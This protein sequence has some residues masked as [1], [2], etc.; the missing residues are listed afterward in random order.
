M[1]KL[2]M[3]PQLFLVK[4]TVHSTS[5]ALDIYQSDKST[6]SSAS[7]ACFTFST[8]SDTAVGASS[9]TFCNFSPAKVKEAVSVLIFLDK[10]F[11]NTIRFIASPGV[12]AMAP[13]PLFLS[14]SSK[15]SNV[16]SWLASICCG[17]SMLSISEDDDGNISGSDIDDASAVSP[18]DNSLPAVVDF[19]EQSTEALPFIAFPEVLHQTVS[20]FLPTI[21]EMN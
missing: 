6:A 17:S 5:S 11:S 12:A 10:R 8:I 4:S 21:A 2:F 7:S 16:F 1:L 20:A 18:S 15:S 3:K 9:T 13:S 19:S 14:S